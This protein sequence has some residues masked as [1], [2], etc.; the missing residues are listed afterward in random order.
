MKKITIFLAAFLA[1]SALYAQTVK[2][3]VNQ[4]FNGSFEEIDTKTSKAK[5]WNF[6]KNSVILKGEKGNQAKVNGGIHQC[7]TASKVWQSSKPRKIQYSFTV[8]GKGKLSVSFYRYSDVKDPKA[9]HGYTRKF[10]PHSL[11]KVVVLTDNPQTVTGTYTIA[12]N[13][14]VALSISALDALVDDVVVSLEEEKTA[15]K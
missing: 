14:W 10:L 3:P 6:S 9:K 15:A 11:N 7:L 1:V 13:E 12:A 2:A 4:A 5:N 8:S